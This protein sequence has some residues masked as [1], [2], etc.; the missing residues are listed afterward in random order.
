MFP[1]LVFSFELN[2]WSVNDVVEWL[3]GIEQGRFV[4]HA[5]AFRKAKIDGK[6]LQTLKTTRALGQ[7]VKIKD[8]QSKKK[9]KMHIETLL[10]VQSLSLSYLIFLMT[11]EKKN[12]FSFR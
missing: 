5:K 11:N 1:F 7:K 2:D 6:K 8:A 3:E 9:I 10:K 12:C 4:K